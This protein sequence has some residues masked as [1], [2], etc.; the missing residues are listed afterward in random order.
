MIN[1]KSELETA[2]ANFQWNFIGIATKT[3]DMVPIPKNST[4]ISAIIEQAALEILGRW[5]APHKI[6]IITTATTREYPDATLTG[7]PFGSDLIALDVKTSRR[8][9]ADH[10]SKFTIGSY[11]G[12]FLY[13][14]EK[15]PGC[16]RPYH[17]FKEH[18]VLG[19]IYTWTPTQSSEHMV[20]ITDVIVQPK[21]KIASKIT[22]TGTTKHIASIAIIS[23]LKT[24]KGSFPSEEDFEKFWR[25]YGGV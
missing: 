17:D 9:N 10:C 15:R 11:A 24:G 12:Y 14:D 18:W 25:R 1:L 8:T 7:G 16:C 3:G 4:C 13:P 5:A 21:W 6:H 20:V 2:F 19:F 23:N 22:G